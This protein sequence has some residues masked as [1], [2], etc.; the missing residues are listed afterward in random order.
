MQTKMFTTRPLTLDDAQ[1][2]IELL[3]VISVNAGTNR[4]YQPNYVLQQWQEP[5]FDIRQS[6]YGIFTK[7]QQLIGFAVIWDM[8]R[9]PVR[10][11]IEW[12]VH[13]EYLEDNL[14]SQL[15]H[16]VDNTAQRIIDRCPPDARLSL[17]STILKGYAPKESALIQA[18]FR[19]IRSEYEMQIDMI[20]Q[21]TLQNPPHGFKIRTY[22]DEDLHGF[23]HAFQDA[24]SDHF[25]HVERPFEKYLEEFT[26]WFAIPDML[27]PELFLLAIDQN[28]DEIVGFVMGMK[29]G[30]SDPTA[31]YIDLVGICPAYR[32]RGL[33]QTLLLHIFNAFWNREQKSVA[34][35]VD[36]ASLTNAVALYERVGMF[37]KHHYIRYEKLIREGQELGKV[38]AE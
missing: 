3:E 27:D 32:R 19:E 1:K 2:I 23:V 12:G 11:W 29:E 8:K 26:H 30:G 33:A 37:I 28:T 34:L 21:P 5:N 31:G 13:P 24:W 18:G 7:H 17:H 9:P 36:G 6:S 14:S 10:P 35:E 20:S 25:G 22:R 16:W 38:S 4:R 15:L